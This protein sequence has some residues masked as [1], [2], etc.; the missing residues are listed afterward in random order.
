MRF[1]VI[2]ALFCCLTTRAQDS[3]SNWKFL[4]EYPLVEDA[5]WNTDMLQN[6]YIVHD[7]MIAKYDSTGIKKFTQSIKSIGQVTEIMPINTMKLVLFSEDQQVLCMLDNTLTMSEDLIDLSDFGIVNAS[8]A[9]T[10]SQPEKIWV[11]DQSNSRL[12]LLD[13]AGKMQF[14][15]VRN[16][17][18]VLNLSVITSMTESNGHLFLIGTGKF[19]EFDM[20]GTLLNELDY[21][22]G[23]DRLPDG[24]PFED[25]FYW[26]SEDELIVQDLDGGNEKGA[27]LPVKQI[28]EFKKMGD[29]YYFRTADKILKYAFKNVR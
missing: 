9:T 6:V 20:Y 21:K 4:K 8:L 28:V 16:L 27:K 22:Y 7:R 12:L 15:E 17:K 13:L 11:L 1:L 26:M 18:G 29:I 2:I 24:V 5:I 3:L 10:S 25:R 23:S 14:Q 19:Y